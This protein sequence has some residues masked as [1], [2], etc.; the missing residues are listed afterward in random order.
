[1]TFDMFHLFTDQHRKWQIWRFCIKR[2]N[3][4]YDEFVRV[5][6]WK[7]KFARLAKHPSC[8]LQRHHSIIWT[9]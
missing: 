4:R 5:Y 9:I 8:W 1:V 3:S 7:P 2:N 6:D